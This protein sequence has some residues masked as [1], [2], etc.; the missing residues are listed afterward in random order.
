MLIGV[1]A[2]AKELGISFN[3]SLDDVIIPEKCPVFGNAFIR[4]NCKGT[5]HGGNPRSPTIDR[6]V[7]T[8]G[9][10]KGNVCIVS[11][12]A[13]DIKET[14]SLKE[15]EDRLRNEEEHL[16]NL[17]KVVRFYQKINKNGRG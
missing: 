4:G 14:S 12:K 9:Y 6:I 11:M 17:R 3:L 13:N 1:K 15:L 8:K 16:A 7:P 2:R 10:I 5:K